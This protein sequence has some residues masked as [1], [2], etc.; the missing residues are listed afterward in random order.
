MVITVSAST[1]SDLKIENSSAP[2]KGTLGSGGSCGQAKQ[3]ALD[4]KKPGPKTVAGS[5]TQ[6]S[7]VKLKS[8]DLH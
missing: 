2:N 4:S 5:L 7:N 6:N 8:V 3:Q 1:K